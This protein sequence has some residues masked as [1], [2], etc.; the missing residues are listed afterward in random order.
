MDEILTAFGMGDDSLTAQIIKE[1]LEKRVL[2]FNEEVDERVVENYVLYIL[3][4]NEEDK[5]IPISKRQPIKIYISSPG[6]SVFDGELLIDVIVAS[7]TPIKGIAFGLVASM[8]YRIF[9]ACHVRY[10]FKNTVLLQHDGEI[11]I[12]NSRGKAKDTMEFF[13]SMEERTKQF[14]LSRTT[15]S[16]E[17]Y[18]EMYNKECYMYANKEGKE[19]GCVDKIIGEDCELEEIF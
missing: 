18:D 4:W 2:V 11:A 15:M 7:K 10:A 13:N 14:V 3:K 6:G 17:F 19:Y 12:N 8:A 9:L 1:N 5:D 16:E